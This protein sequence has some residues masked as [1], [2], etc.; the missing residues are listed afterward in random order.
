VPPWRKPRTRVLP[1]E[2]ETGPAM[3]CPEWPEYCNSLRT[4]IDA[5]SCG[6][7]WKLLNTPL[8]TWY[9]FILLPCLPLSGDVKLAVAHVFFWGNGASSGSHT[10]WSASHVLTI[11]RGQ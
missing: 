7:R 1:R 6:S 4:K 5:S 11:L 3:G 9:R 8:Q 2:L 10:L